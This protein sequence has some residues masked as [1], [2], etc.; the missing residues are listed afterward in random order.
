MHFDAQGNRL[1]GEV[2]V[3]KAWEEKNKKDL[4]A[5]KP[6]HDVRAILDR[7]QILRR[8]AV[9]AALAAAEVED[10]FQR[11]MKAAP[12]WVQDEIHKYISEIAADLK[13][14]RVRTKV[15]LDELTEFIK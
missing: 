14:G 3:I 12:T 5:W 10:E 8:T 15:A 1:D 11:E 4:A 6:Y 9:G 2:N 7:W 13:P